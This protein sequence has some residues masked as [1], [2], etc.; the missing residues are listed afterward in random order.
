MSRLLSGA[1]VVSY[2]PAFNPPIVDGNSF[3]SFFNFPV[4]AA[5]EGIYLHFIH[6]LYMGLLFR[7]YQCSNFIC[8]QGDVVPTV[9][10]FYWLIYFSL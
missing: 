3:F 4:I 2:L 9:N 6:Q 10:Y 7:V 8:S 5:H 1:N